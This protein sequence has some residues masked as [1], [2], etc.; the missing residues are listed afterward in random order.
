M[1]DCPV[2][3]K[4]NVGQV[5]LVLRLSDRTSEKIRFP[6]VP[7]RR[8]NLFPLVCC[9]KEP[10]L[11]SN[12]SIIHLWTTS[13]VSMHA[14]SAIDCGFEPQS[15]QSIELVFAHYLSGLYNATKTLAFASYFCKMRV[16][17]LYWSSRRRVDIFRTFSFHHRSYFSF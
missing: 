7:V 9:I 4:T 3:V 1:S 15:D 13:V 2:P 8:T 12:L 6:N 16:K 11:I 14:S 5:D 10:C 17:I